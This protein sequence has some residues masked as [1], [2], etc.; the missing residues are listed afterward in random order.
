M[1]LNKLSQNDAQQTTADI[2]VIKK[3][4]AIR[5]DEETVNVIVEDNV[6]FPLSCSALQSR[7]SSS[8]PKRKIVSQSSTLCFKKEKRQIYFLR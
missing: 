7:S 6:T 1:T 2:R 5:K 8:V 4:I 3:Q